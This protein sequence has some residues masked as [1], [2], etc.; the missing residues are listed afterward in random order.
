VEN[1]CLVKWFI[2]NLFLL[3]I[4]KLI[5]FKNLI[6][7]IVC[8]IIV[9]DDNHGYGISNLLSILNIKNE[10]NNI[11]VY[12]LKIKNNLT[13]ILN[14]YSL[15]YYNNNKSNITDG[16]LIELNN[17]DIINNKYVLYNIIKNIALSFI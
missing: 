11:F 8:N 6:E 1:V 4:N 5:Y 17:I 3:K 16:I 9:S 7:M 12:N 14:E 15:T 10:L 2:K 13:L